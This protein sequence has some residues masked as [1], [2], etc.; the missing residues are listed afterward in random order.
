MSKTEQIRIRI[1]P[2]IKQEAGQILAAL[3]LSLSDAVSLYMRQI[4]TQR[5]LPFDVRLPNAETRAA[6]D[7]LDRGEGIET[8]FEDLNAFVDSLK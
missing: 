8:S 2:E 3:G 6:M 5:G 4:I 1:E 7:A